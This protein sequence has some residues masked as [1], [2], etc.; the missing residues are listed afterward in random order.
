MSNSHLAN[1]IEYTRA[2]VGYDTQNPPRDL[3]EN[4]DIFLYLSKVLSD[5]SIQIFDL[6]NGSVSFYAT[7][8]NPDILFN[9]HLDTVPAV[10]EWTQSPHQLV[11]IQDR[12]IG[13]GSCDIKGAAACLIE[14]SKLDSRDLAFLFTTDEEGADGICI[15]EFIQAGFSQGYAQAVVAEPTNCEAITEHCGFLSV[16]MDFSGLA[17]HSS[18]VE[19]LRQSANH[20][21]VTWAQAALDYVNQEYQNNSNARFN[22]GVLQ[23][24][25][26]SNISAD[27]A[28]CKW[29]A[30]LAPGSDMQQFLLDIK[31]CAPV[32]ANIEW[33][34]SF[35]GPSLPSKGYDNLASQAFITRHALKTGEPVGFWTEASL[36]NA[37]GLPAIVLGPGDI[38][39]AHSADEF[40]LK[41]QLQTAFELYEKISRP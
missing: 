7:R 28:Y 3:H 35:A 2:L 14:L 36:F 13:L 41:T 10:N 6:G 4:S 26:K 17:G 25:I 9:V 29:S 40:V 39:Q 24:G 38:K 32:E 15:S 5:F 37:G 23:G 21:L 20:H 8:G 27:R 12:V 33:H 19:A 31:D 22:I 18:N 1:I 30:R 11:E 16:A 34:P